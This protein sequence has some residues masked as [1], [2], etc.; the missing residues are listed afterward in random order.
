MKGHRSA[1]TFSSLNF[2]YLLG[3]RL[4]TW[5]GGC[6]F[7]VGGA[8]SVSKHVSC[9]FVHA[10]HQHCFISSSHLYSALELLTDQLRSEE[11][12]LSSSSGFFTPC[13]NISSSAVGRHRRDGQALPD[14][15]SNRGTTRY[16]G[17]RALRKGHSG[18]LRR[19][20]EMQ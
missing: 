20:R 6:N 7:R 9:F 8:S 17:S 18:S 15:H 3:T 5:L 4:S 16:L 14:G 12:A 2:L 13:C 19:W 1:L 11:P 10:Y